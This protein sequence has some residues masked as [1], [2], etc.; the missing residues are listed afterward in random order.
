MNFSICG[1]LQDKE[2]V[3]RLLNTAYRDIKNRDVRVSFCAGD[4][5]KARKAYVSK[6]GRVYFV[7]GIFD[8]PEIQ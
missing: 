4:I 3:K 5:S 2:I 6:E 7:E 1:I 8:T